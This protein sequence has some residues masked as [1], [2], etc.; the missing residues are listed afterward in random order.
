MPARDGYV[1]SCVAQQ[2]PLPEPTTGWI[3][4]HLDRA[5][6]NPV[7]Q[8]EVQFVSQINIDPG[9][10][11]GGGGVNAVAVVA[12]VILVILAFLAV[13][14]LF[15]GDDG[16]VDADVDIDVSSPTSYVSSGSGG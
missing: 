2:L 3:R 8:Q 10:D 7:R 14:F 1:A 12:I 4:Q 11:S 15:L 16:D 5:G 9:G 13:Y 6:P